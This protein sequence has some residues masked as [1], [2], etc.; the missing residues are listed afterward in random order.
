MF[1]RNGTHPSLADN[2]A[3]LERHLRRGRP[4][5][6][7]G[8]A[9]DEMAPTLAKIAKGPFSGFLGYDPN[10]IIQVS[11]LRRLHS[12]FLKVKSNACRLLGQ[13]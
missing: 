8:G 13:R 11:L 9:L 12:H 4:C 7:G 2:G 3:R 10:A 1:P 6:D 5:L